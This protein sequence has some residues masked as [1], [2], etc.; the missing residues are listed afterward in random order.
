M[1]AKLEISG[2]EKLQAADKQMVLKISLATLAVIGSVHL[3]LFGQSFTGDARRIGMG[4]TGENENA[5]SQMIEDQRQYRSIVVPLG[6]IQVIQDRNHFNPDNDSFNPV[7]ALEDVANPLHITWNRGEKTDR[8]VT[9]I[10]NA[11]FSR[12][13]NTYRGFVPAKQ[14]TAQGLASP[15]FGYTFRF[16]KDTGGMFDGIYVGAGPYLSAQTALNVDDK[17]IQ[18]L[19][20]SQNVVLRNAS[21]KIGDQAAGQA[22]AAVTIGYRRRMPLPGNAGTPRRNSIYIASNYHYLRGF[23]YDSANLQVQFDTDPNGLVTLTPTTTPVVGDHYYSNKGNGFALDLGVGAVVNHWQFGVGANGIANRINW[24]DMRLERFTLQSLFNGGG[25]V[26]Q[27]LT[28]N[29]STARVELP[30]DTNGNVGYN[31]DSWAA[32]VQ[33]GHG[34]QGNTFHGGIEK[35]LGPIDFRGGARY[36]RELWHPAAGLGL[37]LSKRFAVD[38]AAFASTS[39]IQRYRKAAFAVSLR[40]N[41]ETKEN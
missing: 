16:N 35:R 31:T 18:L 27:S 28:S 37:N 41:H 12:D 2:A 15:S 17:L 4:G 38:L 23:R 33:V 21:L 5:G 3:S 10:V 6:L 34:F 11:R 25:F 24:N 29:I 13:L 39:N 9:D 1:P 32:L 7:R 20:S 8:F 14:L 36:S 40:L 19:S 26:R 30:V 22:A